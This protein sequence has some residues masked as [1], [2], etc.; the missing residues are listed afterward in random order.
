MWNRTKLNV[1]MRNRVWTEGG[2]LVRAAIELNTMADVYNCRRLARRNL[3]NR[4]LIVSAEGS[5]VARDSL[6]APL[7]GS[8]LNHSVLKSVR[9]H[10]AAR[11]RGGSEKLTFKLL[12]TIKHWKMSFAGASP[13][14]PWTSRRRAA[15]GWRQVNSS[16]DLG[17]I[18]NRRCIQRL[19]FENPS[20]RLR[21]HQ[22]KRDFAPAQNINHAAVVDTVPSHFCSYERDARCD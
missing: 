5:Q 6:C 3:D 14:F 17:A 7:N 22:L 4:H 13:S 16:Y 19:R 20:E 12:R 10:D 1:A 18:S 8:G 11:L 21:C 15:G 9:F 2:V